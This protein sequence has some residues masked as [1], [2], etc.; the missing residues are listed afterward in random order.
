[1]NEKVDEQLV[2]SL[3]DKL[4]DDDPQIEAQQN[5]SVHRRMDIFRE[6]LRRD[7]ESLLNSHKRFIPI[8]S[9]FPEVAR[10]F[11]SFGV[12]DFANEGY[13]TKDHRERLR[14]EI[15]RA[16]TLHEPRLTAIQVE[17]LEAGD[18]DRGQI[19]FRITA[20]ARSAPQ[21]EDVTFSTAVEPGDFSIRVEEV[22]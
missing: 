22:G 10:S 4:R 11:I 3:I 2:L 14:N 8:P 12:P 13:S 15:H 9:I 20:Q 16:L 17:L 7:I 19:R 5:P 21:S 6:S 18:G 1:M